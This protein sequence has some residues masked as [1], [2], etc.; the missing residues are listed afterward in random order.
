[1]TDLIKRIITGDD[2]ESIF[3]YVLDRI[4]KNGP[5]S[6]TDMEILSFLELYHPDVFENYK[7]TI[8]NYMAVFYKETERATLKDVVFG[9]YRRYLQESYQKDYTP[10]QANIIK[11]INNNNCFSFSAPTSTG[12]SYV[13]M[14]RIM[15]TINDVVVVVPSRALINEYYLKLSDLISDKSV[16]I[17]TFVDKINTRFSHRN[18]FIVTPERCRE[19]FKQKNNFQVDLFLFDEAQQTFLCHNYKIIFATLFHYLKLY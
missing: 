11:G 19:L 17:L 7:N 9:Q 13:F 1:M 14:N 18:V 8:L 5:I 12:K 4:F 16:N 10:V 2:I 15:D 3:I 6:V